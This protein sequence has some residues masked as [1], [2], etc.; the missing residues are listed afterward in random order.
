MP[1]FFSR[2]ACLLIAMLTVAASSPGNIRTIEKNPSLQSRVLQSVLTP[3]FY[4][5]LIGTP[6]DGWVIARGRL[7]DSG[8]DGMKIVQSEGDYDALA[9]KLASK[10]KLPSIPSTGSS[11]SQH[12]A[13]LDLLIYNIQNRK[14]AVCL[15]SLEDRN[16]ESANLFFIKDHT[17]TRILPGHDGLRPR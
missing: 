7:V 4:K 5:Q 2:S 16:G 12:P 13:R 6:I 3:A 14:I 10:I 11:I 9:L 1:N 8:L 17:C 15:I